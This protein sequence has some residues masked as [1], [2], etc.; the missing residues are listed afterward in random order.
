MVE[1]AKNK[2]KNKNRQTDKLSICGGPRGRVLIRGVSLL[3]GNQ[4]FGPAL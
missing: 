4:A 2:N 3:G 1:V